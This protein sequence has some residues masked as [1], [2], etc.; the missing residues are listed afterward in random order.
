[1]TT[2]QRAVRDI[3][4]GTL[5]AQLEH[6]RSLRIAAETALHA[7]CAH[8]GR[9]WAEPPPEFV[10]AYHS[11]TRRFQAVRLGDGKTVVISRDATG[12]RGAGEAWQE[13]A[14]HFS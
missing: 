1:M 5:R 12:K 14:R 8:L 10:A 11:C 2:P 3:S 7:A 13:I 6:E 4:S 9:P